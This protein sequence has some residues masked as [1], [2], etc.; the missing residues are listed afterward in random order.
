MTTSPR[1][2]ILEEA[3]NL[4]TGDRNNQYGDPNQDFQRIADMVSVYLT[5][6]LPQIYSKI[7]NK[8]VLRPHDIAIIQILLK[9]SRITHSP[10]KRDSWA[11]LAG[12]AACGFDC[13]SD[14]ESKT[15]DDTT[16]SRIEFQPHKLNVFYSDQRVGEWSVNYISTLDFFYIENF[17]ITKDLGIK[18]TSPYYSKFWDWYNENIGR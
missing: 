4:V 1:K 5:G 12:Y 13:V 14:N 18:R 10:N 2:E 9:V 17:F 11:D 16:I 7:D 15:N 6:C 8:F 3:I